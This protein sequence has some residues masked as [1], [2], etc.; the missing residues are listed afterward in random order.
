MVPVVHLPN[1]RTIRDLIKLAKSS[2]SGPRKSLLG[3]V[4]YLPTSYIGA[5]CNVDSP[6]QRCR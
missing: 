3:A 2:H 1:S 6:S 4:Y 5:S